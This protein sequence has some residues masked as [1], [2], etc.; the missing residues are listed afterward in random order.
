M[1]AFSRAAI[2]LHRNGL[3][4]QCKPILLESLYVSHLC[5]CGRAL[6]G[7]L[8]K[9]GQ[10]DVPPTMPTLPEMAGSSP[11]MTETLQPPGTAAHICQWV[12]RLLFARILLPRPRILT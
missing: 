1:R 6:S 7:H 9:R 2:P 4:Y 10:C 5:E 3:A 11:A 8:L 12:G